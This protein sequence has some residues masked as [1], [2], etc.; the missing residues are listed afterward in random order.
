MWKTFQCVIVYLGPKLPAYVV[1][2]LGYLKR[3]FPLLNL[4]FISDNLDSI[5]RVKNIG[6]STWASPKFEELWPEY[7]NASK[8]PSE[9]RDGF[10]FSTT[11]RFKAIE[12]FMAQNPLPTLQLEADVWISRS[13]PFGEFLSIK[14][15]AYPLETLETG[16]ASVIW[17]PD[18]ERIKN[19]SDYILESVA[20]NPFETDMTILG[21]FAKEKPKLAVTLPTRITDLSDAILNSA[22]FTGLFDPLTYGLFILGEDSRNKR[23]VRVFNSTPT[24]H[25]VKPQEVRFKVVENDIYAEIEGKSA[26]IYC[27]HNHSKD[28]SLFISPKETLATRVSQIKPKPWLEF[29]IGVFLKQF[30][31]AILRR[32][33]K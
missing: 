31:L 7:Q 13:F 14:E 1:D 29:Q 8:Q 22:R 17:F 21:K 3:E 23:G 6:I 16:A 32:V 10:W 2:N 33:K 5:R 15:I 9:F 12:I 19:F 27:L 26:K 18:L 30:Q 25:L 28:R 20:R 4:V 11:A 24:G